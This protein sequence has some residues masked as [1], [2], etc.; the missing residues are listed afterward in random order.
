MGKLEYAAVHPHTIS[1]LS[2]SIYL[3]VLSFWELVLEEGPQSHKQTDHLISAGTNEM[4]HQARKGMRQGDE[5]GKFSRIHNFTSS[6]KCLPSW[7][8]SYDPTTMD[9]ACI[10]PVS[11]RS[12]LP[13][14]SKLLIKDCSVYKVLNI[15]GLYRRCEIPWVSEALL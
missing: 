3:V 15:Q 7:I 6:C 1:I 8:L 14:E 11:Q 10:P 12:N 2:V 5:E 4:R 13:T 9:A